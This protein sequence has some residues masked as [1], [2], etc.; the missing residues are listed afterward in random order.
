MLFQYV[1]LDDSQ[2]TSSLADLLRAILEFR[3]FGFVLSQGVIRQ[4][5]DVPFLATV[6]WLRPLEPVLLQPCVRNFQKPSPQVLPLQI[7]TCGSFALPPELNRATCTLTFTFNGN[8]LAPIRP[9]L[10]AGWSPR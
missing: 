10:L 1:L 2:K 4:E 5:G 9:E 6:G 7:S 3:P 8:L